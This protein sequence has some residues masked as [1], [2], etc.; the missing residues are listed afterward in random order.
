V[1]VSPVHAKE[2]LLAADE[3]NKL[4]L[5]CQSSTGTGKVNWFIN[6]VFYCSAG[7]GEKVFISPPAGKVKISCAAERGLSSDVV[8]EVRYY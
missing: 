8:V 4:L 7:V 5:K 2:Y 3:E 6:D 1:I